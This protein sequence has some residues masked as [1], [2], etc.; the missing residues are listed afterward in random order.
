M[1]ESTQCLLPHFA[2][3]RNCL[4]NLRQRPSQLLNTDLG[5]SD[6]LSCP[7]EWKCFTAGA[8]VKRFHKNN[9]RTRQTIMAWHC[10]IM[11]IIMIAWW[12]TNGVVCWATRASERSCRSLFRPRKT[13]R[14]VSTATFVFHLSLKSF[15]S[16][17]PPLQ[18]RA[19]KVCMSTQHQ[20]RAR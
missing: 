17:V 15:C 9:N 2:F 20:A 6:R 10:Y 4:L 19:T 8:N 7:V 5:R 11:R 12:P 1:K 3:S 13:C 16:C 18:R 14:N